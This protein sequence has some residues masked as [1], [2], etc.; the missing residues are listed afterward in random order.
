MDQ[1]SVIVKEEELEEEQEEEEE[2]EEDEYEQVIVKVKE[3][4]IDKML[5]YLDDDE[6]EEDDDDDEL[7]EEPE[8]MKEE[9]CNVWAVRVKEEEC[10]M[11]VAEEGGP[12]MVKEEDFKSESLRENTFPG[13]AGTG[14]SNAPLRRR[15]EQ[16]SSSALRRKRGEVAES[17][18]DLNVMVI[19][20]D[21][22]ES[23]DAYFDSRSG[24]P[25]QHDNLQNGRNQDTTAD[26]EFND[27]TKNFYE[28]ADCGKKFL[29]KRYLSI[30]ER[31]H[32]GEKPYHCN[33][34]GKSFACKAYLQTHQ[35]I[36]AGVKP[37]CCSECGKTF[38]H[39]SYLRQHQRI[40]TGK[41][42]YCCTD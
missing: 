4:P 7:G 24:T 32:T 18:D 41:K 42:P 6:E 21:F 20:T 39:K 38:T 11:P 13:A 8:Q 10:E 33:D 22:P 23:E 34:C 31:S 25:Y 2:E 27:N 3:E 29:Q 28:C 19:P 37:Y 17:L 35:K 40:H 15:E 30:H 16:P 36:H 1:I 14:G 5:S 12:M 9:A 26:N